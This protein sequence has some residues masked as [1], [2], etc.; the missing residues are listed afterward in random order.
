MEIKL[1]TYNLELSLDNFKSSINN[2]TNSVEAP[3]RKSVTYWEDAWRRLKENK[4]A[5]ISLAVLTLLVLLSIFGP[6]ISGYSYDLTD[7]NKMNQFPSKEHWFGTD[8]LGRDV[9]TRVWIGGR[10][11]MLIGLAGTSLVVTIGCIYGG[12]AG[13]FGG[14]IDNFMMRIIEVLMCMPYIIMVIL[15]SL[16]FGKGIFSL[17][18]ALTLTGWI[19]IARLVR[20]QV[21]Q[22]KEQEFVKA[23]IALGATPSRIIRKHLIPNTM[24][25]II[26]AITFTVPGFI[27]AE[28]FLS[29]I[30][31]GVQLPNT[32]WGALAASARENIM[33]YPYQLLFPSLMIALTM[34]S[35]SLLGDGLRDALDPKLRK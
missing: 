19:S 26:V 33:F 20:G 14:K 4:I 24:G 13:Y 12:I 8:S 17:I 15:F 6:Y 31:L 2:D 28:A 22:L 25:V 16:Y 21:L 30:G 35:F 23:A 1:N 9:F 10:V 34:L 27:F 3:T 5:M 32:S 7:S 11:S 18:M 29:F